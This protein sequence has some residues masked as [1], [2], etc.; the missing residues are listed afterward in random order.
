MFS[1]GGKKFKSYTYYCWGSPAVNT[2][3]FLAYNA[4]INDKSLYQQKHDEQH[5]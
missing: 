4:F 5:K 3:E 2:A 1:K